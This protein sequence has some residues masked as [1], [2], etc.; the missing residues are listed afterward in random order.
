[1]INDGNLKYSKLSTSLTVGGPLLE[2]LMTL[3]WTPA[4]MHERM[5]RVGRGEEGNGRRGLFDC[6]C[7]PS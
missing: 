5:G 1:M 7:K 6:L 2:N 3:F 4:A